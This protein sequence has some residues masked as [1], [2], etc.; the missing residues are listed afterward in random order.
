MPVNRRSDTVQAVLLGLIAAIDRNTAAIDALTEAVQA[1]G[2]ETGGAARGSEP[3]GTPAAVD[4]NRKAARESEPIGTP[5][6]LDQDP[7]QESDQRKT[8]ERSFSDRIKNQNQIDWDLVV[9]R[10]SLM[11]RQVASWKNEPGAR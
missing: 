7:D 3:I 1:A 9:N 2:V 8:S 10:A 5:V 11:I 6:A 4:Q